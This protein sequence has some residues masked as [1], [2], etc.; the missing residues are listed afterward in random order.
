MAFLLAP[1]I[2][3]S[4][5][6]EGREITNNPFTLEQS[7]ERAVEMLRNACLFADDKSIPL[8]LLK[9]CEGIAFIRIAK[10]GLGIIGV[11]AAFVPIV[12][13]RS[14]GLTFSCIRETEE[15]V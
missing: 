2:A 9:A 11:C 10:I 15:E 14:F 8:S 13:A 5:Y 1:I 7:V 12:Y 6:S 4:N 3:V